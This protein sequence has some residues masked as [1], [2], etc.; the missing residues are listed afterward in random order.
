M[1]V[2]V[3]DTGFLLSLA[4]DNDYAAAVRIHWQ[5]RE[6]W[7]PSSVSDELRVRARFPRADIPP[8]LPNRALGIIA[9]ASWNFTQG[10]CDCRRG[11]GSQIAAGARRRAGL[12]T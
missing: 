4:A 8:E 1:S 7:V 6:L 12:D 9:S 2:L 11:C 5:D 10:G 3:F